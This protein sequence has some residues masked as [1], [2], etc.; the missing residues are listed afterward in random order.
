MA[1]HYGTAVILVAESSCS[2]LSLTYRLMAGSDTPR[3][4]ATTLMGRPFSTTILTAWALN[5]SS[6]LLLVLPTI[7]TLSIWL[8]DHALVSAKWAWFA[9]TCSRIESETG[10]VPGCKMDIYT[11]RSIIEA[12]YGSFLV[13]WDCLAKNMR[14]NTIKNARPWVNKRIDSSEVCI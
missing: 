1:K 11:L 8:Y 2:A 14:E 9:V 5:W 4:S 6:Y 7:D 12:D 3:S 13:A 10:I